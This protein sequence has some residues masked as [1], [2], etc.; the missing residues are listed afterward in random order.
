MDLA[1]KAAGSGRLTAQAFDALR[2]RF[3]IVH[4]WAMVTGMV[5]EANRARAF[6]RRMPGPGP[7]HLLVKSS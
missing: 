4:A 6:S 1:K 3:N 5:D 2:D 7:P